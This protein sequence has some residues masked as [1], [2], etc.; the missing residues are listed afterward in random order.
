MLANARARPERSLAKSESK[1]NVSAGADSAER[2]VVCNAHGERRDR[3]V[4]RPSPALALCSSV[5][6]GDHQTWRDPTSG[7][8]RYRHVGAKRYHGERR[9]RAPG[10]ELSNRP[11]A[12]RIGRRPTNFSSFRPRPFGLEAPRP[13]TAVSLVCRPVRQAGSASKSHACPKLHRQ[14]RIRFRLATSPIS[15]HVGAGLR[16][17]PDESPTPNIENA[18][19]KPPDELAETKAT[20]RQARLRTPKLTDRSCLESHTSPLGA[21][22]PRRRRRRRL[23]KRFRPAR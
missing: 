11:S 17:A 10:V 6:A 5:R 21:A 20:G 15:A 14:A 4:Q 19:S 18:Q 2:S 3:S 23:G 8:D 1:P 12:R 16:R 13:W 7:Q 9:I 22:G